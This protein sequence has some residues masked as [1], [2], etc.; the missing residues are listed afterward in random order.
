MSRERDFVGYGRN[1]PQADWPGGARLAI[2]FV[3]NYEE[4]SEY[5]ISNGDGDDEVTLTEVSSPT[6]P[7]GVADHGARSMFEYGSRVGW[8]RLY[9]LFIERGISP[10]IFACAMAL[11]RN[12]EAAAAIR[13][14]DFDF[15]CHGWR[16]VDHFRLTEEEE[17]CH[18]AD[19]IASLEQTL[20]QRPLGWY[21]RYG[22]SDNTRRLLIEEGGFE[23]DSDA[24]NDELPYWVPDG[25]GG[26]HLV[27][28]YSLTNNDGQF[29]RGGIATGDQ[30]FAFLKDAFDM[31]R[32]EGVDH[33]K[34][35][36]V[37][38]HCRLVGHPA[39][40]AGLARF[41]DYIQGFDDIWIARRLDIARHWCAR[42]P[43]VG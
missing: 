10:T 40:A 11:E 6:V 8:W 7:S 38:L 42:H 21:C 29:A 13:E 4:G 43:A 26:H 9:R 39:R 12:P 14:A 20:G 2:N 16:W 25:K 34:M 33:P 27:V 24:Y 31:L 30:F 17:R 22:P 37:G 1:L 23:Y 35:M 36:S 3:I 19:A 28:P 5:A 18:I 41:L 15:L 32:E